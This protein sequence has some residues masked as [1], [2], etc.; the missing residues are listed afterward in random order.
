M[1][2]RGGQ[3]RPLHYFEEGNFDLVL[4]CDLDIRIIGGKALRII[5]LAT[6]ERRAV[7]STLHVPYFPQIIL[8]YSS[9]SIIF[10]SILDPLFSL[11]TIS[12]KF[13]VK[14]TILF[15][16]VSAL[17]YRLFITV[18]EIQKSEIVKFPNTGYTL[19]PHYKLKGTIL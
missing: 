8:H 4:N 2:Y 19:P 16:S 17:D 5:N 6:K 10:H 14:C 15:N 18:N 7:S 13:R 9:N 1:K 11:G 3:T 12:D